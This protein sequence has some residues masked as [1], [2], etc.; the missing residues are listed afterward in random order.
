MHGMESVEMEMTDKMTSINT[1][2][3]ERVLPNPTIFSRERADFK[4]VK[5]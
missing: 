2:L 5:K 4:L 1:M 3:V